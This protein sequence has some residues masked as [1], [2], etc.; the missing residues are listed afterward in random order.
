[1]PLGAQLAQGCQDLQLKGHCSLD[2]GHLAPSPHLFPHPEPGANAATSLI[3]GA[4][5]ADHMTEGGRELLTLYDYFYE[6]M[7]AR[8]ISIQSR[9]PQG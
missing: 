8:G 6:Q 2:C 9:F 1:M 4:G 7:R 5:S 3:P